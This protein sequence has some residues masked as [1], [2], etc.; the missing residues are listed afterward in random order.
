MKN[1]F[2]SDKNFSSGFMIILRAETIDE[3]CEPVNGI[4]QCR[5]NYCLLVVLKITDVINNVLRE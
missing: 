1:L 2:E 3:L 5:Q 4:K